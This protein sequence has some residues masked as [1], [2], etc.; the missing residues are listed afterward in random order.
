MV[1]VESEA[2]LKLQRLKPKSGETKN[3]FRQ[4]KSVKVFADIIN[5][6]ELISTLPV[7]TFSDDGVVSTFQAVDPLASF[8]SSVKN[9][10]RE[11][12]MHDFF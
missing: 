2:V 11:L 10:T 12:F 4:S 1:D 8:N 7:R 5:D 3:S 6:D 9:D